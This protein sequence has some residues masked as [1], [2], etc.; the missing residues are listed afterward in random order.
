MFNFSDG[1]GMPNARER[2]Q[3]LLNDGYA[4]VAAGVGPRNK[5]VTNF[6]PFAAY[7]RN[8]AQYINGLSGVLLQSW[9]RAGRRV[10]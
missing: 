7:G 10:A 5:G 8:L 2:A 4:Y 6:A 3:E 9:E 1:Q